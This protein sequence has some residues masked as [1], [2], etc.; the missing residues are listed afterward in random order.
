MA[1]ILLVVFLLLMAT[2]AATDVAQYKIPN[3]ISLSVAVCFAL[4]AL[5]AGM[6]WPVLVM[7]LLT[8]A[9]ILLLGFGLFALGAIGGGDAKLFAAASLWF[10]WPGVTDYA[11]WVAL[12]GGVLALVIL[13]VRRLPLKNGPKIL[14][15]VFNPQSGIPYGVALFMGALIK[16]N[17]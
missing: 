7:H 1:Y 3:W 2:A 8:G 17:I 16:I 14:P 9:A 13:L 15:K 12:S 4:Y 11:L 10:G 6:A 5:F